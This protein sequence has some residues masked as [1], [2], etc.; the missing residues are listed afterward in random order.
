[1]N[2]LDRMFGSCIRSWVWGSEETSKN[3]YIDYIPNKKW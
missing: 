3:K 1:M 2:Y